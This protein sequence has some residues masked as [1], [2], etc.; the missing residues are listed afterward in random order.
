[1]NL[2]HN[3][4]SAGHLGINRTVARVKDRFDWPSLRSDVESWCKACTECQ[5]AKNVTKK[6]RAKVTGFQSGCSHGTGWH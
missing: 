4:I 3:S 2:L 5:K 1:M 6:P